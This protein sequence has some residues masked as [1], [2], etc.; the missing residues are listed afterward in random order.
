LLC[1]TLEP[2]LKCRDCLKTD[3]EDVY[4]AHFTVCGKPQWCPNPSQWWTK[5]VK[6]HPHRPCM[7]LFREWH[8]VRL[9]LEN[10]WKSKYPKY[11]PVYEKVKVIGNFTWSYYLNFSQG[12]C[13]HAGLRGYIRMEFP[14]S[15]ENRSAEKLL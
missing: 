14:A 12:H 4:T 8:T 1:R 6:E 15:F 5:D 10:E 2:G 11:D 3:L 13:K 9:S 7:E